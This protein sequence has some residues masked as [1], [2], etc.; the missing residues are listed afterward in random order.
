MTSRERMHATINFEPVDRPFRW[1]A[2]G[3]W[4]S[5]ITR[6]KNEG[7][8]DSADGRHPDYFGF[9]KLVWLPLARW[10]VNP[11]CPAF[12]LELLADE[13]TTVVERDFDGIVKRNKKVGRETSMPQFLKFPVETIDDY[14]NDVAWRLNPDSAERFPDNWD[15]LCAQYA[16]RDY[17]VGL[18]VVGPFG[19]ARNLFGEENLMYAVYDD[20]DLINLIMSDW[21]DFYCRLIKRVCADVTPD[22]IMVWED[23]CY[24]S[25]PLISPEQ[26]REFM[27][28][29]LKQILDTAKS[30]GIAGLFVDNDGDCHKMIPLYLEAGANGF[31]P[32]ECKAGMDIVKIR[33]QYGRAFVIIGGINKHT[34]SDE[35][36]I[37][38]MIED[39]EKKVPPLVKS[40]GYIPMLDHS[41]P[42]NISLS[43]FMNFLEYVR[44]IT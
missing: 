35:C 29:G 25:G 6:W 38:E 18:H 39:I 13:E 19:F 31:Y 44:K 42:P 41:A 10:T 40:G 43:H 34:L 23:M 26:F 37:E 28:D 3:I 32:F 14:K 4:A 22:I 2:P 30:L 11:Y 5:T 15:E 8:P 7:L 36:S 20:P 16:E 21:C 1:E 33:E 9:D 17:V 27:L 24:N 12:D